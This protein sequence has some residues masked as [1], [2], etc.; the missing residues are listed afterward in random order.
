MNKLDDSSLFIT[1]AISG[2]Q[3]STA[4]RKSWFSQEYSFVKSVSLFLFFL[5]GTGVLKMEE[6]AIIAVLPNAPIR[7]QINEHIFCLTLAPG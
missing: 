5:M 2:A 4:G 7:A 1:S 6:R 3:L